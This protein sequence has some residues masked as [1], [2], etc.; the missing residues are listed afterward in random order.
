VL[1]AVGWVSEELFNFRQ[2]HVLYFSKMSKL[3]LRLVVLP[4]RLILE[5][6]GGS[7]ELSFPRCQVVLCH[8][9]HSHYLVARS[10]MSGVIPTVPHIPSWYAQG[11]LCLYLYLYMYFYLCLKGT[12]HMGK[13]C[14]KF[15]NIW[16]MC[17]SVFN[18]LFSVRVVYYRGQSRF[19]GDF[20]NSSR[21]KVQSLLAWNSL[22]CYFRSR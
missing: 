18:S 20:K 13:I 12:C 2:G 11:Q 1:E 10:S 14:G 7:R 16:D 15:W 6:V 5:R 22:L 8:T 21:L 19:N 17:A 4:V 3:A 9:D